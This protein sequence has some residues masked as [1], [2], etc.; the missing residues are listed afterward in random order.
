M[1]SIFEIDNLVNGPLA[2]NPILNGLSSNI[3]MKNAIESASDLQFF[4]PVIKHMICNNFGKRVDKDISGRCEFCT[5]SFLI[6][7]SI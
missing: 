4:R 7:I 6:P 3:E 5:S 2:V 1:K